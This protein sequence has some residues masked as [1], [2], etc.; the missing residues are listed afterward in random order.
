MAGCVIERR[1]RVGARLGA[2]ATAVVHEAESLR[3]ALRTHGRPRVALKI[4]RA[5]AAEDP[6]LVA[7]FVHEAY[8]GSRVQHPNLV[9]VLDFGRMADGRPYYA[10]ELCRGL[11]LDRLLA[12]V[13][14]LAP[15][16]ALALLEDVAQGLACLHRHGLVHR[17]VKPSNI[18]VAVGVGDRRRARLLDLGIAGVYDAAK[19]DRLGT[20]DVG[21]AG[22][23]GTPAYIAPEQALGERVGPAADVY[24]LACVAYRML[25]G[26]DP[27]RGG[28]AA[29]TVHSHLFD[30][31]P[32]A[33]AVHPA[34]PR[35]VDAVFARALR[36]DP[37]QRT[38]SP[39][40]LVSDL[41][42]S[43]PPLGSVLSNSV[44]PVTR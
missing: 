20:V 14:R 2:G 35:T 17:D 36:K 31:A 3:P 28:S 10:M 7:L 5:E 4:L 33:S 44:T 19:A 12:E 16:E 34:L 38:A 29:A 15:A 1:Y 21:S 23:H 18:F 30:E 6:N 22:T 40:A 26:R 25:T 42:R 9:P 32:A 13:G 39:L 41:R 11:S 24:A 27:F 43:I 8:V 37:T